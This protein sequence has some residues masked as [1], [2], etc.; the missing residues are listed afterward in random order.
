MKVLMISPGYPGEM[1]EFTHALAAVGARVIGLGDQPASSLPEKARRALAAH[2]QVGN[3][4]D[5]R[6]VVAQVTRELRHVSLDRVECL[7]EP[8]MILAARLREMLDLPGLTVEQTIPFRDKERMKQVLDAAGIRTPWHVRASTR[9]GCREA[10]EQVGYPLIVKPIEGA[11]A[12]DTYRI[13]SRDELERIL[14][15]L[16]HVP[17]IS[18]EEFVEGD[19]LTYD[20]ICAGGEILYENIGFYRPRP[21]EQKKHEWISPSCTCLRDLAVP[22]LQQ[23]RDIGRAVLH[24]LGFHTGFSHMEWYRKADGEVVFGE[25]GA[26][27]PGAHLVEAMNYASDID[28]FAGWAEAVCHG[29]FSQPVQRKYNA[30]IVFKRARGQ[31]EIRQIAGLEKLLAEIGPHIAAINLLPVGA[32]RR[33]WKQASISDGF[34]IVRHPDLQTTFDLT[35]RV[36]HELQLY[37][38]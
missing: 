37:A 33:D 4:W 30:A 18:V 15:W 9:D 17:E 19:E 27:P 8:G 5:E 28:V 22:D 16:G 32:Q 34:L 11:G 23:G 10:A 36:G 31:G 7:W 2:I 14:P 35:D 29:R 26:R 12:A 20:T 25:I 24:A 38:S 1:P 21:L 13:D 3:L 6:A